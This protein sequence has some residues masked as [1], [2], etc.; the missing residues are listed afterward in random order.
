MNHPFDRLSPEVASQVREAIE[1]NK[2]IIVK[3]NDNVKGKTTLV[4]YL[5]SIGG[6]AYEE[7]EVVFVDIG[8]KEECQA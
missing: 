3:R 4:K 6:K 7:H 1:C 5:R 2:P 8:D